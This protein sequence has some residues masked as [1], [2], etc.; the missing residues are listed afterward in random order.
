LILLIVA[1]G[2]L[3]VCLGFGLAMYY[4]F[5]PPDW[6]GIFEAFGPVPPK[7]PTAPSAQS[8]GAGGLGAPCNPAATEP[9]VQSSTNLPAGGTI[10]PPGE[11]L[12]EEKVLDDV[13]D[14]ATSARTALVG[15][16][17]ENHE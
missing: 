7:M 2:L 1:I 4:G 17:A 10:A 5:G 3:N 6:R 13:H 8:P 12:A 16:E 11:L 14:L 15:S 9:T